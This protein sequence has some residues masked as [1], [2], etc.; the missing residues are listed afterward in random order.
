MADIKNMSLSNILKERNKRPLTKKM[1]FLMEKLIKELYPDGEEG[2]IVS[3]EVIT[4][5][6]FN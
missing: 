4:I 1:L 3:F 5:T 6:A 2:F